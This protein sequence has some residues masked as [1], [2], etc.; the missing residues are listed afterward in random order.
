L[1]WLLRRG[2]SRSRWVKD[3]RGLF[4]RHRHWH[5]GGHRHLLGARN[6]N[7]IRCTD[8]VVRLVVW[9]L[10]LILMM[11]GWFERMARGCEGV[12]GHERG[13]VTLLSERHLLLGLVVHVLIV[14]PIIH[15]LGLAHRLLLL[16]GELLLLWHLH[17]RRVESIIHWHVELGLRRFV[18]L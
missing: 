7:R 5:L 18:L 11:N 12:V 2:R 15:E 8:W 14:I 17:W 9:L 1:V 6:R 13:R 16:I 10:L 3:G 4:L